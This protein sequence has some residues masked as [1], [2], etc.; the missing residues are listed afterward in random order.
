M[1]LVGKISIV[2]WFVLFNV[3]GTTFGAFDRAS[4]DALSPSQQMQV[5]LAALNWRSQQL[6]NL[7][8]SLVETVLHDGKLVRRSLFEYKQFGREYQLHCRRL[9][10]NGSIPLSEFWVYWDGQ[11]STSLNKKLGR[12]SGEFTSQEFPFLQQLYYNNVLGLRTEHTANSVADWIMEITAKS[13]PPAPFKIHTDAAEK[14]VLITLSI[15]GGPDHVEAYV[16]DPSRDYMIVQYRIEHVRQPSNKPS[17][18]VDVTKASNQCGIWVP[19][20]VSRVATLPSKSKRTYVVENISR[21]S[22]RQ[23]SLRIE[24]PV[25]TRVFDTI[26]KTTYVIEADGKIHQGYYYDAGTGQ[27]FDPEGRVVGGATRPASTNP[28]PFK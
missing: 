9:E 18:I 1:K 21:D 13:I 23:E 27:V 15:T 22:A 5:I 25:G 10:E 26:K 11:Q 4:F 28:A 14:A 17:I 2:L 24:F 7:S 3:G 8:Y 19:V 6:G 12:S 16:L 20:S